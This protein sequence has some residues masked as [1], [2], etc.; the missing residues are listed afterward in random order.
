ML[1]FLTNM[2]SGPDL[3][4]YLDRKAQ[5][6]DVRTPGEFAQG[7]AKGSV[8]IPLQSLGAN[9]RKLDKSRPVI[10]CCRSG[11]RSGI[12]ARQL[13]QAGFEAVNGGPWQQVV[14]A[15]EK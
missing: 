1:S 13:T 10:T 8:N 11:N 15:L 14:K 3:T 7:H 2:F 6:I 4:E 5:I 9:L 12:A